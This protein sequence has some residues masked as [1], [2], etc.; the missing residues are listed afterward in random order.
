MCSTKSIPSNVTK[1]NFLISYLGHLQLRASLRDGFF[2]GC[3]LP[4]FLTLEKCFG[5]NI[6]HSGHLPFSCLPFRSYF[7]E[8]IFHLSLLLL[9]LSFHWGCFPLSL[10][11]IEIIFYWGHHFQNFTHEHG[12]SPKYNIIRGGSG[13]HRWGDHTSEVPHIP[14]FDWAPSFPKM[15]VLHVCKWFQVNANMFQPLRSD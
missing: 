11:S 3:F 14:S 12:S 10:S 7:I 6:I 5:F 2:V 13:F 8:V 9:R 1:H 15:R 4:Y